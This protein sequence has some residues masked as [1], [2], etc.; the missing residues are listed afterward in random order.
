M[1]KQQK[2]EL[3]NHLEDKK[4]KIGFALSGGGARGF[5]HLGAIQALKEYGI[6]PEII[7]GTSAGALAGVFMAD[8][9]EPAEVMD[10]FNKMSFREFTDFTIPKN[11]IFTT[12]RLQDLLKKH[13][14][15]KSFE[16]LKIPLIVNTSDF[17]AGETIYFSEGPLIMPIV[18]SCSFP[19]VFMPTII[20]NVQHADGGLLKNFPVSAIRA[21]CEKVVGINVSPI[22][23]KYA[24]N[25]LIGVVEKSIQFLLDATAML[26]TPLCDILIEPME[27]RK[28]SIFEVKA[29]KEIY[30]I[31]YLAAKEELGKNE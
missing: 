1:D 20:N 22:S 17:E 9:Y 8:G 31:G 5:A 28:H 4:Y 14:R 27:V 18:A 7:S 30:E 26:D 25:N 13:I 24:K 10:I 11:G 19:I 12:K 15:A 29:A 6:T 21:Q 2:I 3:S 16:E 23:T